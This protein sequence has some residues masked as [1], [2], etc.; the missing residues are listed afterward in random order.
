MLGA[1]FNTSVSQGEFKGGSSSE[2][3][4]S[5]PYPPTSSIGLV[6][7]SQNTTSVAI[8][9]MAT[10]RDR[11]VSSE[12]S[13]SPG[14]QSGDLAFPIQG[15]MGYGNTRKDL[16]MLCWASVA[17]PGQFS[18]GGEPLPALCQFSLLTVIFPV[19]LTPF[20]LPSYVSSL[21]SYVKS[22]QRIVVR[23]RAGLVPWS[24]LISI[25]RVQFVRLQSAS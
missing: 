8:T 9:S 6:T 10:G 23:G 2:P 19:L 25:V 1:L 21:C 13:F 15:L 12:P 24:E 5:Q 20:P 22:L 4:G 16:T 11:Q 14:V 17:G 18:A 3:F 7:S